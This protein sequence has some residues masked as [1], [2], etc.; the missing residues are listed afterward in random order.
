MVDRKIKLPVDRSGF[1]DI[2]NNGFYYV[3]KSDLIEELLNTD[4]IQATLI[5]RPR[6]FGKTLAMSMLSEFFDIRKTSKDIFEG[7]KISKNKELCK[8]WQ[9]QYPT[10]FISFRRVDGLDFDTAY[11][12]FATTISDL[13]REHRYIRDDE[14]VEAED[15]EL[16]QRIL[17]RTATKDETS[18]ALLT[19]GRLMQNHFGKPIILLIDEYDVPLAKASEKG[20]YREMLDI[21]KSIM[22][23]LKDNDGLKFAVITGCLRIAKESIF[24]GTN[25]LVSDTISDTRLDEC[26]GFTQT[27][28]DKLLSDT[29]LVDHS[30]DIKDWYDGYRFGSSEV[31]CPWDVMN[32]VTDLLIDPKT[33][34]KNYWNN[35]S[36]NAIVRSFIE[37]GGSSITRRL[38]TLLAGGYIIQPIKENLT[39]N[40]LTD[41][42]DKLW[43][44]L[45]ST[46]YLTR[47]ETNEL[48]PTERNAL[49]LRIPNQEVREIYEDTVLSWFRDRSRKLDRKA[50]FE[51]VWGG[52]PETITEEFNKLLLRT[53]SFHD[54]R[55]DFY[56]AFLAGV[57]AGAGYQIESNREHGDGRSDVTIED[58][59]GGRVAIFEIKYSN[60]KKELVER[61]EEAI[62]QINTRRYTEIFEQDYSHVLCYGIAFYKK[63]CFVKLKDD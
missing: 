62:N 29:A 13:Y 63:S 2:R 37:Y 24:T 43:S 46:G 27:E 22:Q 12:R 7:L 54:Y 31:Y 51:A 36:D 47:A 35:S 34:P 5:T 1:A 57:F 25:N 45:Y 3:D 55:E 11:A 39:Y 38:E 44:V 17:S 20:Y 21:I 26:F 6:R 19:L 49:P 61:C 50:L 18:N 23:V 41:S 32:Y 16:F 14:N 42:E 10:L 56:H 60:S 59:P 52:N 58:C 48:K 53:I 8:I 4:G 40:Y 33:R 30:S 28:V 9:N 15:L